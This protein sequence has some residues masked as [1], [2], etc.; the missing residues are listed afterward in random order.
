MN[1]G[2]TNMSKIPD[3]ICNGQWPLIE[4]LYCPLLCVCVWMVFIL[5]QGKCSG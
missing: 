3:E 4:G 1:N 2:Q 5:S